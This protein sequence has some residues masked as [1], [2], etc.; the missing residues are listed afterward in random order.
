[1][2]P[3]QAS[4]VRAEAVRVVPAAEREEL[5]V[6]VAVGVREALAVEVAAAVREAPA[7]EVAD[8]V[9]CERS[10]TR[11]SCRDSSSP[12]RERRSHLKYL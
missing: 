5:A 11:S 3:A 7:A 8:S 12:L 9:A 4:A 10:G 1:M 2:V 6:A